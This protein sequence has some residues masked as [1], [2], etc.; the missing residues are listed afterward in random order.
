MKF[1]AVPMNGLEHEGK[2]KLKLFGNKKSGKNAANA[3]VFNSSEEIPENVE[4]KQFVA[5]ENTPVNEVVIPEIT[6]VEDIV[7]PD[8]TEEGSAAAESLTVEGTPLNGEDGYINSIAETFGIPAE[9]MQKESVADVLPATDNVEVGGKQ[10]L[11]RAEKK[12]AK[13]AAKE[14]KKAEKQAA[15]QAKRE[16]KKWSLSKKIL[17]TVVLVFALAITGFAGYFVK[18]MWVTQDQLDVYDADFS[19]DIQR[20]EEIVDPNY[21]ASQDGQDN[22]EELNSDRKKGCYTFLVAARDVAS[23]CTDVIIVGMFDTENGKI[24]MVSIPRD[25]MIMSYCSALRCL[26][27]KKQQALTAAQ[28]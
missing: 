5:E 7:L 26:H 6:V 25:T 3:A 18:E 1:P 22:A 13:K 9:E 17:V 19:G 16:A 14:T 23:G 21:D 15:K 10:K 20:H 28:R 12:Q 24:N 11:T 4:Q 27:L 8:E 2:V